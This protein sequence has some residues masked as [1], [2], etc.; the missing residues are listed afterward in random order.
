MNLLAS[1]SFHVRVRVHLCRPVLRQKLAESSVQ[2]RVWKGDAS[3]ELALTSLLDGIRVTVN[4][5]A[6]GTNTGAGTGGGGRRNEYCI[7]CGTHA[8]WLAWGPSPG[9]LFSCC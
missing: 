9:A 7:F 2:L 1:V 6:T 8:E 3:A 5:A 4:A